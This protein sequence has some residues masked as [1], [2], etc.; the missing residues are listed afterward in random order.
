MQE[1]YVN[2]LETIVMGTIED[3]GE[4]IGKLIGKIRTL[5]PLEETDGEAVYGHLADIIRHAELLVR[6]IR[7]EA[8]AFHQN[9]QLLGL[10]SGEIPYAGFPGFDMRI[11][12]RGIHVIFDGMLPYPAKGHVYYLHDGLDMQLEQMAQD[13]KLPKIRERC[14]VVF[15]HHYHATSGEMRSLRDYDN[16]ERRCVLNVLARHFLWGDSPHQI[17]S[18]DVL[19]PGDSNYTEVRILPIPE[20]RAFVMSEEMEYTP[21]VRNANKPP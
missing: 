19:A 18:M 5:L 3:R 14:G 12:G 15:L 9:M 21:V 11:V 20:F 2:E 16:L 8:G 4:K 6:E 17:V 7:T 10:V 13:G 1:N